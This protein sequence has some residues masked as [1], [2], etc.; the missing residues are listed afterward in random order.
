MR[1]DFMKRHLFLFTV[2]F[3]LSACITLKLAERFYPGLYEG[4]A[5]GYYGRIVLELE[6]DSSSILDIKILEQHE[7][8]LIGGEAIRELRERILEENS[9]DIDA[10]SGATITSEAFLSALNKALA[11]ALIRR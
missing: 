2:F 9:T 10:I 5:D 11:Q 8:E 1:G 6:T 7:D 4:A 3:V